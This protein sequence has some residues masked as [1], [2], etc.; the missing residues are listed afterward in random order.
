MNRAR[1]RRRDAVRINADAPILVI[2]GMKKEAACV[3]GD[4]V[5]ALC[6]G[7]NVGTLGAML[8]KLAGS[9]FSCVISFGLAGALDYSL[10]PGDVMVADTVIA[11][12]ARYMTNPQLSD[13]LMEGAATA[14]CKAAPGAVVGVDSPA[15]DVAAKTQLRETSKAGAVDME[16]H[17]AAAF[18]QKRKLP[19]A[20]LRAISDPAARA[21][22][23][24]AAN[25]L[26]PQGDVDI[27][28]VLRELIR[29]P[30]QL[31][32]LILAGIDS[33]AAFSS[34]RRC[35]P[36]LRPLARLVLADL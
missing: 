33:R 32:G 9:E 34:L 12:A 35:G 16:S 25:A 20:V 23:P 10:R 15:M 29:A 6:S 13:V 17:L 27:M 26:T 36:L 4:G 31:G 28:K 21:L 14:G 3:A 5:V 1:A 18:A 24:L 7:A 8:D 22:P 2:T 30:D 19:F 11:G